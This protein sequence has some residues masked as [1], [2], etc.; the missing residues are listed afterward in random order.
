MSGRIWRIK[1]NEQQDDMQNELK[2][3]DILHLKEDIISEAMGKEALI[4]KDILPIWQIGYSNFTNPNKYYDLVPVF[5]DWEGRGWA[6]NLYIEMKK[7]LVSD[8]FTK[9]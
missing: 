3:G 7:E 1:L 8:Y 2:P 6:R 4:R 9:K 5:D